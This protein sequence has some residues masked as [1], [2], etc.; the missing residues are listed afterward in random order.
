MENDDNTMKW[1]SIPLT[2]PQIR[3]MDKN[4]LNDF[5]FNTCV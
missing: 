5:I 1:A 4:L 2:I 3:T